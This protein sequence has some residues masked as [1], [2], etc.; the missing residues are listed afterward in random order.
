[1]GDEESVLV[2]ESSTPSS[3]S[4][5]ISPEPEQ[6]SFKSSS[7]EGTPSSRKST[8]IRQIRKPSDSEDSSVSMDS[9]LKPRALSDTP[10]S[11]PSSTPSR[12]SRIPKKKKASEKE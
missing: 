7:T 5:S 10:N 8:R 9:P 6:K 11:T 4:R 3:G 1:M 12:T 2:S